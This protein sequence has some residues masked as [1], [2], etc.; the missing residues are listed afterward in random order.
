M[1][2]R[3]FTLIEVLVVVAIIG[4]LVALIYPAFIAALDA[5]EAEQQKQREQQEQIVEPEPVPE[6]EQPP[7]V[8]LYEHE[9]TDS[10]PPVIML[11]TTI[12][13]AG[14][15]FTICFTFYHFTSRS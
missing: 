15:L 4:I 1:N 14:V 7:S 3:A 10:I 6:P 2:R 9:D 12:F 13:G 11:L 8:E 5:V